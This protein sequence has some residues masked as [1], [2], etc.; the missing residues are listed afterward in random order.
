MDRRYSPYSLPAWWCWCGQTV[1]NTNYFRIVSTSFLVSADSPLILPKFPAF[2][3]SPFTI[4]LPP[5]QRIL[6][7]ERYSVKFPA[8]IP[9]VGINLSPTYGSASLLC[10]EEFHNGKTSFDRLCDFWRRNAARQNRNLLFQTVIYDLRIKETSSVIFPS[11]WIVCFT[12]LA[13][14]PKFTVSSGV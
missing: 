14:T 2:T 11:P 3:R 1:S 9:P 13:A 12:A 8:L 10:R 7:Q 5:Q 4:Q 6:S